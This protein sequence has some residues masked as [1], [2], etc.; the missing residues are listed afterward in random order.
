MAK[1][2]LWTN[3]IIGKGITDF[4]EITKYVNDINWN[5]DVDTLCVSLGFS[6]I[7]DLA[8]GRSHI[9]L[10]KD[11]NTVFCGV[12]VNKTNNDK[13][14][15]YTA[16]DYF[17]YLN[18]D[19]KDPFQFTNITAKQAI[20]KILDSINVGGACTQLNTIINKTYLAGEKTYADLIKNII[21]QCSAELGEDVCMEMRAN[22]VLWIDRLSNLKLD[23]KYILGNDYSIIRSMENMVNDVVVINSNSSSSSSESTETTN[24]NSTILANIKDENNINI[25]G[26]LIKVLSLT[27]KTE[28]EAQNIA[29]NYLDNFNGTSRQ[30]TVTLLDVEGCENLRANRMIP[31]TIS[32]YGV[33]GEYKV[34]SASHTVN[35]GIH[36]VQVTIDFSG[37]S[38]QEPEGL[39]DTSTSSSSSSSDSNTSKADEIIAY[40]KTFLGVPYVWGGTSPSGFDCSGLVQYVYKQFGYSLPRTTYEQINAGTQ[41]SIDNTRNCDLVFFYNTGHVGMYIGNDQFIQA[42]HT[43][44]VVKISTFSGYYKDNCNAVVRVLS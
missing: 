40:A 25:F 15:N 17:I 10:K 1:W 12:L 35:N 26:R 32:K 7:L 21:E 20:Y 9:V 38:F 14:S 19:I 23:C 36:K 34:K 37:V 29:K 33:D 27:D 41:V 5:D 13:K 6:S 43:G 28:A 42:P 24:T 16:M 3:Y 44:D 39:N 2:T 18:R 8:E 31:I 11:D 22:N 4:T 30:L